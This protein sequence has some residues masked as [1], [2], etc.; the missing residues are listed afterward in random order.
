M[1]KIFSEYSIQISTPDMFT[2]PEDLLTR[3][4]HTWHGAAIMWHANLDSYVSSLKTTNVRFTCLRISTQDQNFLAIS[5]YFPTHGKDEEF[6]ECTSDLTSFVLE[7]QKE[8]EMVLIGTDY[9]CSEKSTLRRITAFNNLTKQLDLVKVSTSQP[10]FHHHNGTSESNIDCYL[11]S[12]VYVSKL[13]VP[14]SLCT[15]NT[16]ENLSSHDPVTATLQLPASQPSKCT[17][18]YSDT[19]TDFKQQRVVWDN[20]NLENY[21]HTAATALAEY[22]NM[23]PLLEHIPLKCELF[24]RIL[25]QS[26]EVCLEIKQ[27]KEKAKNRN[28]P[29]EKKNSFYDFNQPMIYF[30]ILFLICQ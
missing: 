20:A 17:A 5:V 7:N 16:P 19:F 28:K 11:I 23:F 3:T 2:P 13:T 29:S 1:N 30:M 21:Q 4:D 9:N 25:V 10:T 8:N 12:K 18:D 27:V 26:A 15:L 22:E 14:V 24:S 6:L